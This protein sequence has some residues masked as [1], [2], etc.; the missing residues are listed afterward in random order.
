MNVSLSPTDKLRFFR[1]KWIRRLG[2]ALAFLITLFF[3]IHAVENWRGSRAWSH[4]L[5]ELAASGAELDLVKLLPPPVPDE[6][7]I[8]MHPTFRCFM[9]TQSDGTRTMRLAGDPVDK[10]DAEMVAYWD[11]FRQW[12]GQQKSRYSAM[13]NL[14]KKKVEPHAGLSAEVAEFRGGLAQHQLLLDGIRQALQRPSC[15]W[16]DIGSRHRITTVLQTSQD[17]LPGF[18][19]ILVANAW[20]YLSL[21]AAMDG[22]LETALQVAGGVGDLHRVNW[23]QGNLLTFLIASTIL[24]AEV[25][26]TENA[27]MLSPTHSANFLE[28]VEKLSQRPGAFSQYRE[29]LIRDQVYGVAAASAMMEPEYLEQLLSRYSLKQSPGQKAWQVILPEGWEK[30]RFASQMRLCS[31]RIAAHD[32]SLVPLERIARERASIAAATQGFAPYRALVGNGEGDFAAGFLVRDIRRALT[33]IALLAAETRS[34]SGRVPES[35]SDFPAALAGSIPPSPVD[36]AA[37]VISRD[38]KGIWTVSYPGMDRLNSPSGE[39]A[40]SIRSW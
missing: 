37:P 28:V 16:P 2:M 22:D 14:L 24:N 40:I 20:R 33:Q 27:L 39:A 38:S 21:G 4:T 19:I 10:A 12:N 25:D 29:V 7:N 34:R 32:T 17:E 6:D 9:F 11:L 23:G 36:G 3:L 35:L 1:F 31:E 8:A 13:V 18:S 15:R 26:T 30:Q 5:D